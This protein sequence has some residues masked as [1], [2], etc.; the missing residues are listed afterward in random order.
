MRVADRDRADS[1]QPADLGDEVV[2]DVGDHVEEHVAAGGTDQ[3]RALAD[4]GRRVG[5]DTDDAG[6]L[7]LH[8][9]PVTLPGQLRETR[10]LLAIPADVLALIGAD[11]AILARAGILDAAGLADR[12]VS[13]HVS[14]YSGRRWQWTSVT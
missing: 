13:L 11:G 6:S 3:Q 14:T 2:I 1:A 7:L 8:P 5:A 12:K 9:A 10:P 4:G